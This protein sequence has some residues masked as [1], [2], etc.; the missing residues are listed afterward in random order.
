MQYFVEKLD[1]R[2]TGW[3]LWQ[4][5]LRVQ[6]DF[7]TAR[8]HYKNFHILRSWMIEQY[9][10]SSERDQYEA[11]TNSCKGY[12]SFDPPWAWHVDRDYPNNM[13]IYIKNDTVLSNITLKWSA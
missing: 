8:T 3:H 2:H 12:E 6:N 13:Y 4:Y 7:S 1:K 10:I 5:R 11:I 9:G